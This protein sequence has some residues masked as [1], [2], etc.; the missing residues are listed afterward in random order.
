MLTLGNY[1][2][3]TGALTYLVDLLKQSDIEAEVRSARGR[4]DAVIKTK[5]AIFIFKFKLNGS[6]EEV[7]LQIEEKGYLIPFSWME[8]V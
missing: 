5:V 2:F 4:A 1:C 3:Q 8:S 7:L 6:D